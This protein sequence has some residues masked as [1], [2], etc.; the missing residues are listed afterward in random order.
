VEVENC[1]I[2]PSRYLNPDDIPAQFEKIILDNFW[3]G[4]ATIVS[5]LVPFA[6]TFTHN[7]PPTQ[8]LE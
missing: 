8:I 2:D 4:I 1:W 3:L 5:T 6:L 7:W